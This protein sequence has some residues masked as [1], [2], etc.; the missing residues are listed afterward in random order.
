MEAGEH[1]TPYSVSVRGYYR[2]DGTYV[3][4]HSRRPPGSVEHDAPYERKRMYMGILFFVCLV[5]GATSIAIYAKLSI[6]EI[7]EHRETLRQI[8]NKK[9]EKQKQHYISNILTAIDYNFSELTNIP[10]NLK[11]GKSTKCKFCKKYISTDDFYVSFVAVSN[12]H[13]VCMNCVQRRDPIGRNQP[14][15]KYTNDIEYFDNYNKM[16]SQF[17]TKF[18]NEEES[19]EFKFRDYDL[20]RIF[21]SE[22]KKKSC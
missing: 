9:R 6:S 12:R 14:R 21:D 15:S 20:K 22:L 13:F 8:E 3:G 16:L 5:G 19:D 4:P 2:S 1:L 7:E 17:K 18:R 10:I 11:K